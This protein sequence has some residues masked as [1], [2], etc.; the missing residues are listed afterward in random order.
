[1]AILLQEENKEI[2]AVD[3]SQQDEKYKVTTITKKEKQNPSEIAT[4]DYTMKPFTTEMEQAA[5]T[6]AQTSSPFQ[7]LMS[8]RDERL[9]DYKERSRNAARNAKMLAWGNLFTNLAKIAGGGWAPVV[10][11]DTGFLDKA[12]AEADDLRQNY[13]KTDQAYS[14]ALDNYKMAYVENARK[15]HQASEQAKY[16]AAEKAAAAQNR[17]NLEN[18][19][20]TETKT[21][22][23]P[24][25]AMDQERKDKELGIKQTKLKLEKDKN[26]ADIEKIRSQKNYYDTRSKNTE[27]SSSKKGVLY[28]FDNPKDGFRY[29][30]D[31]SRGTDIVNALTRIKNSSDNKKLREEIESDIGLLT[32]QFSYGDKKDE[33]RSIVAKYLNMFP[34][35]FADILSRSHRVKIERNDDPDEEIEEIE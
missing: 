11:E 18:T 8:R 15:A 5:L 26:A 9:K 6:A 3:T 29:S 35:E 19:T 33:K 34:D 2:P 14:D 13:Y 16:E 28:E 10:K 32:K 25:K 22:V 12:F 27:S 24:T 20:T 21:V 7:M 30:I 31:E 23:D 17:L 4:N 1:M